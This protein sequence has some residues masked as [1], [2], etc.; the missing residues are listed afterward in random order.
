MATL[1]EGIKFYTIPETALALS[2]TPQTVRA[3][4]NQ[5]R[6]KKPEDR[7]TYTHYRGKPK[8]VFIT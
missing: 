4:I 8:G 1:I 5:G 3:W 6:I 7:E 2:V